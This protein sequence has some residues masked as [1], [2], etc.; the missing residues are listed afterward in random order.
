MDI[1]LS[2][3][4]TARSVGLEDATI[5]KVERGQHI[6]VDERLTEIEK[7]LECPPGTLLRAAMI[8]RGGVFFPARGDECDAVVV[9]MMGSWRKL[10]AAKAADLHRCFRALLSAG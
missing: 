10:P 9:E 5:G 7:Y 4:A 2:Q 8:D 1:G 3:H 6:L